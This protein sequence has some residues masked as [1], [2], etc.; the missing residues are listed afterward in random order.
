MEQYNENLKAG[1]MPARQV[2]GGMADGA[3]PVQEGGSPLTNLE[4]GLKRLFG[5]KFDINDEFSQNLLL[6]HLTI[7][8]EQNEKLAAMLER[9]PRLAQMISD[10]VEGKRNAHSAMA[11]Y[12]GTSM[13]RVD[14]GSPEFEEIMLADEERKEEIMRLAND[15][16]EYERNLERSLPVIEGFC[17]ERGY[18]ASD[19]M[20]R[21]W[22]QVEFPIMGGNYTADVCVALDHALSYDKDVEDAFAAGSVKGRNM[23]IQRM[24]EDYSDGL[25]KGMSSVAP[26][27]D[28]KRAG[29]SLIEKA[30]L[31]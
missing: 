10:M 6:R 3:V 24:R 18:D 23:N 2:A 21:V 28:K 22:E 31:A 30:L 29:N 16:R 11:R 9:D 17:K 26:D 14:E 4:Q 15:R 13:M 12:F 19:F 20:D 7:N 25:P 8:R 1:A 5:D 27:V